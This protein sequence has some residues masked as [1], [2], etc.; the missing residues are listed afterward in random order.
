MSDRARRPGGLSA[1]RRLLRAPRQQLICQPPNPHAT[2]VGPTPLPN[3][4]TCVRPHGPAPLRPARRRPGPCCH[5]PPRGPRRRAAPPRP[6]RRAHLRAAPRRGGAA[7][8]AGDPHAVGAGGRAGGARGGMTTAGCF[9]CAVGLRSARGSGPVPNCIPTVPHQA[10]PNRKPPQPGSNP[11]LQTANRA[12]PC[13]SRPTST[14][15]RWRGQRRGSP[16][17]RSRRC[18]GE[19]RQGRLRPLLASGPRLLGGQ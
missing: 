15:L 16:A 19:R 9:A 3:T 1:C 14:S 4:P 8:G 17:Q 13:P 18:A 2:F 11:K 10:G 5:Q 12:V 7:R 6:P